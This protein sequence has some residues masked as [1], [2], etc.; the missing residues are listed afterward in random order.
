MQVEKGL[1]MKPVRWGVLGVSRH[2]VHRVLTPLQKMPDI[3]LIGISSRNPERA[4]NIAK[5]YCIPNAY[6]SYEE[7][8]KDSSVEAVY[9]PLPNHLHL[10]WI[11][12]AAVAGKHILC[13]KPL[14]LNAREASEAMTYAR[15]KGV[16]LMEAFMYRFHPLWKRAREIVQAGKIKTVI[17]RRYPLEQIVEVH[18][19]V[20]KGHKKGH[21]VITVEHNNKT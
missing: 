19:Y 6:S 8:L 3:E 18:R 11:K 9:I 21:V 5:K 16:I 12:R 4:K 15:D 14:A 7:L 13:E 10:T 1:I 2:F 17:D 20:E